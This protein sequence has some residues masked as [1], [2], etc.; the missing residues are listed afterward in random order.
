MS[1]WL[2]KLWLFAVISE[3]PGWY[4]YNSTSSKELPIHRRSLISYLI[5]PFTAPI[6][7]I[8]EQGIS[9]VKPDGETTALRLSKGRTENGYILNNTKSEQTIPDSQYVIAISKVGV[10]ITHLFIRAQIK[11]TS[12]VALVDPG[13]M[14]TMQTCENNMMSTRNSRLH[15]HRVRCVKFN[16]GKHLRL[17][18]LARVQSF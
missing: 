14:Q 6:G 9:E 2:I 5:I 10:N 17:V 1:P 3:V 15:Q 8:K 12:G 4:D 18:S 11:W 16:P 7:V 13:G